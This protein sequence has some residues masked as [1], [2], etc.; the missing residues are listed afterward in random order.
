[1]RDVKKG[2][3]RPFCPL[4]LFSVSNF[5]SLLYL[6]WLIRKISW[7]R[8]LNRNPETDHT[9]LWI[10]INN[11]SLDQENGT[12]FV[13]VVSNMSLLTC[14]KS[15]INIP[16]ELFHKNNF[17]F[18]R[19]V[20]WDYQTQIL[21]KNS[22]FQD[23]LTDKIDLSRGLKVTTRFLQPTTKYSMV[24]ISLIVKGSIDKLRK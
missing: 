15:K 16:M 7:V 19:Q 20:K 8:G 17:N 3:V 14:R 13:E 23:L 5:M 6:V 21:K 12:K 2:K 22:L 9:D 10:S 1:M 11:W 4:W 18:F 24:L